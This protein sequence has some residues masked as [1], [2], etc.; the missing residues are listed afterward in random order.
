MG[1]KSPLVLMMCRPLANGHPMVALA[2][3]SAADRGAAI[4]PVKPPCVIANRIF[5]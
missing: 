4:L 2:K 1:L 5:T 3:S